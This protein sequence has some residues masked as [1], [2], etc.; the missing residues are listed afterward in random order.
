VHG[1]DGTGGLTGAVAKLN[2]SLGELTAKVTGTGGLSDQYAALSLKMNELKLSVNSKDGE[3]SISL[4]SG[5]SSM[6][7]GTINLK[8]M[9]TFEALSGVP[10][11][12]T[13]GSI[14][15]GW[16]N[17]DTLIVKA[18]NI[19]GKLNVGDINMKGNI[20]WDFLDGTTQKR[21]KDAAKSGGY[22]EK[23]IKTFISD[24]L[25]SSPTIAGGVFQDEPE[26]ADAALY[27]DREYEDGELV[28]AG[29]VLERKTYYYDRYGEKEKRKRTLQTLQIWDD[30]FDGVALS[31]RKNMFLHL[32]G[33]QEMRAYGLWVFNGTVDFSNANVIGL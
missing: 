15:G 27:L 24:K 29:V 8:G 19:D 12:G 4:N 25:V 18:A 11:E 7:S 2:L 22:T 13:K 32:T 23:E 1:E 17:A 28:N 31:S 5:D 3:V 20:T 14:N 26:M 21:I 16:I 33:G 9:V 30:G 6:G 10:G